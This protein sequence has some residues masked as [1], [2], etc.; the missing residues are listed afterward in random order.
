MALMT[1]FRAEDMPGRAVAPVA[2][3][4]AAKKAAP[5]PKPAATAP[6]E[7]ESVA[8]AVE[9]QVNVSPASTRKRPARGAQKPSEGTE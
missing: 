5:A 4:A 1:N 6:A 3:P 9:E 2:A 8:P 7:A